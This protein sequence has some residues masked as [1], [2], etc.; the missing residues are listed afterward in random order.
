VVN[1]DLQAR[2]QG[3]YLKIA[4]CAARAE[5]AKPA[6]PKPVRKDHNAGVKSSWMQGFLHRPSPPLWKLIQN[7]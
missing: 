6:I 2:Y 5:V 7:E 3:R 4:E 1:G